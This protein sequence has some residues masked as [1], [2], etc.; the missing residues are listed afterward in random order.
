[1][2]T[3]PSATA[4]ASPNIALIKYW[5][6][7]DNATNLPS[8]GSISMTLGGLETKTTVTFDAALSEDSLLMDGLR[9]SGD[10]LQRVSQHLDRVRELA[11]LSAAAA[12]ESFSNFPAGAGLASSASAF[13]SLSLAATAAAGLDLD[14]PSLSRLARLGSGSACRSVYGGFVEWEA[15]AADSQSIAQ[16]IAPQDHWKL[17]DVIAIVNRQHK[18]VSSS[19]GHALADTSPLQPARVADAPRRLKLCRQ[20]L[21][22]RSFSRLASVVEQDSNMMHAVMLTSTP[23]LIYWDSGTLTLM[24]LVT[25]WRASGI[26][27]CYTIDAGPNVHC[28]C[29][30]EHADQVAARL[31][32]LPIVQ[33]VL[34]ATPG[35]PARLIPASARPH[36][37]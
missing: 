7:R 12:V 29:T 34:R 36:R 21:L 15:G 4:V 6:N 28:L 37:Q 18:R 16:S 31:E 26:Q 20:A 25:S 14:S 8:N 10:D 27:V 22:T 32:K 9:A 19:A 2:A 17:A 3:I 30:E 5:G 13:A 35:P 11:G 24:Q 1:M 33:S 23:P